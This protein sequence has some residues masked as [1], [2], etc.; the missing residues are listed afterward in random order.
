MGNV[1]EAKGDT[2]S[3][4]INKAIKASETRKDEDGKR[5]IAGRTRVNDNVLRPGFN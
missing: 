2:N 5:A 1:N 4:T 3:T